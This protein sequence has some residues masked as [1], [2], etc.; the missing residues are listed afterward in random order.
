VD[1]GYSENVWSGEHAAAHEALADHEYVRYRGDYYDYRL[2]QSG[3]LGM[4][5]IVR[6][7]L[8]TLAV[9]L[10]VVGIF[11]ARS[12]RYRPLTP[13]RALWIPLGVFA[14]LVATEYYDVAV[15]GAHEP[16]SY[17]HLQA[18]AAAFVSTSVVGSAVRDRGSLRP[19]VPVGLLVAAGT[20]YAAATGGSYSGTD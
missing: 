4:G 14:A 19:L 16:Q 6:M 15:G 7:V 2:R 9:I 8:S 3:S 13:G 18:M 10:F 12:G 1:D 11:A 17:V 20:L 5:G